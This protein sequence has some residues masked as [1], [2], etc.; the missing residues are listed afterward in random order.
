MLS[1]SLR[2]M[3]V[4]IFGES[5]S[6]HLLGG[7]EAGADRGA[8]FCVQAYFPKIPGNFVQHNLANG[9]SHAQTEARYLI[10]TLHKRAPIRF[11]FRKNVKVREIAKFP[12]KTRFFSLRA[13]TPPSRISAA[14][15][16]ALSENFGRGATFERDFSLG[17]KPSEKTE[18]TLPEELDRAEAIPGGGAMPK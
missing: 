2:S 5:W 13:A 16:A 17:I 11:F 9:C 10:G 6:G 15:T 14:A 8:W 7:G 1:F 12:Y 4:H 18:G 3:R